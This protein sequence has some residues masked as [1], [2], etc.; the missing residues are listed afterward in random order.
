LLNIDWRILLSSKPPPTGP[1]VFT[2]PSHHPQRGPLVLHPPHSRNTEFPSPFIFFRF[3]VIDLVNLSFLS[4]GMSLHLTLRL[5]WL[6]LFR[7]GLLYTAQFS[8][9]FRVVHFPFALARFQK[10]H[11]SGQAVQVFSSSYPPIRFFFLSHKTYNPPIKESVFQPSTS[12]RTGWS[13]NSLLLLIVCSTLF[14]PCAGGSFPIM[15]NISHLALP[16]LSKTSVLSF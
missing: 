1:I 13:G 16:F 14:P 12:L 8:H 6:S 9:A 5:N 2:P 10:L 4:S 3:F 7:R 11:G 15:R